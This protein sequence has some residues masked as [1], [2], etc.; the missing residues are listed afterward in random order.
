MRSFDLS[1]VL[2][3]KGVLFDYYSRFMNSR[4]YGVRTKQRVEQV[5][6]NIGNQVCRLIREEL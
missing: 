1:S 3:P 6:I 4:W 5:F 2:K